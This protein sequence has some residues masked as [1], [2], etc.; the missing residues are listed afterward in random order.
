MT[1]ANITGCSACMSTATL[2]ATTP[3]ELVRQ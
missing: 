2:T 3:N 1:K